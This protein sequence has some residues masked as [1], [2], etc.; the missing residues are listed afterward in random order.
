MEKINN[1][2]SFTAKLSTEGLANRTKK[3]DKIERIFAAKTDKIDNYEL[4][5]F[6]EGDQFILSTYDGDLQRFNILSK[7]GFDKLNKHTENGIA[8]KLAKFLRIVIASEKKANNIINETCKMINKNNIEE[9]IATQIY[10][11]ALNLANKKFKNTLNEAL[12]QDNIYRDN[13]KTN[14][15]PNFLDLI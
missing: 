4:L 6:N 15:S 9:P 14:I 11:N 5:L 8:G 7:E 13:L 12:Q 1:K 10:D 3:W 2:I